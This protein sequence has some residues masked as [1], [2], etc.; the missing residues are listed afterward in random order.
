M[1]KRK[2]PVRV[3][4]CQLKN[5]WIKKLLAGTRNQK[6]RKGAVENDP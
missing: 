1:E 4:E 6:R 3:H 5:T 2:F